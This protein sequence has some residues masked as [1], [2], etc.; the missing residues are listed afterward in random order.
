MK[1]L[2]GIAL[3]A[4]ILASSCAANIEWAN[5]CARGTGICV[6]PY[7][8]LPAAGIPSD[9][10]SYRGC[11]SQQPGDISPEPNCSDQELT[12]PEPMPYDGDSGFD[13]GF[14][15]FHGTHSPKPLYGLSVA[16]GYRS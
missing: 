5:D 2:S 7:Y 9:N 8:Q 4:S 13:G 11:L 15:P 6:Q 16:F 14:L 12:R 10:P 1:T 3:A